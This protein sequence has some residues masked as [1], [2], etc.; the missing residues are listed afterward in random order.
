VKCEYFTTNTLRFDAPVTRNYGTLD[1]FVTYMCVEGSFVIEYAGEETVMRKGD[2][3]L[4]PACI[5]ELGL[6]PDGE[7]TLLEIY[8]E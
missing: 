7:V 3:V 5:D 2:T 8:I 4:I 1:T 6:I